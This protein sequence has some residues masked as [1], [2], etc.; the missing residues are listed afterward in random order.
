MKNYIRS[1]ILAVGAL[2][3]TMGCNDDFVNTQ[4]LDQVS[5]SAVWT[6]AVLS[7]RF[8]VHIYTYFGQGGFDEQMIASLSDE[9][10][11]THTG[12]GIT[13]ITES[14]SNPADNGWVNYTH[15]WANMYR[16]I[17][18]A[19][20]AIRNL[21]SPQFENRNGV[22]EQLLGEAKF[23]RA[24]LYHQ[25]V[26]FY[27]AVPLVD[28]PYELGEADY[29]LPRN[30]ME[31]CINFIVKD[32]DDAASLI[33]NRSMAKGRATG[34]AALALKSRILTYAA[35]DLLD[36]NTAKAKSS[37]MAAYSNPELVSITTGSRAERWQKAK[38]AAK[39]VVDLSSY[40][41]MLNL[42]APATT[43]EGTQNFKN[44][45]YSRNGGEADMILGR[46]FTNA[47]GEA[48][49]SIGLYN[50]PNGYHN[51]A[52]NTPLQQFVDAFELADGTKFNWSNAAHA[53]SPYTGRD[54]R[55]YASVLYDGANWKPRTADVASK[56]PANQI[57]TGQYEIIGESGSK[58][59]YNGLD[60]R[61]SSVEDWNGTRTGYYFRK[62]LDED[63]TIEDQNTRQE[64]PWPVLRYTEAVLNYIEACIELGEEQEARTWLNKIRF[65]AGM[66]AVTDSGDALRNR[67]RNERLIELSFESHRYHDIRRWMIAPVTVGRKADYISVK[68]TL[69]P[70]KSVTLY[71]Y[72]TENY[73]YTYTVLPIDPGT[74][75]RNWLDKMYF[76]PIHRDEINRNQQLKQ[77][78]GF[79]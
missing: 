23:M 78:P 77:N 16:G 43:A 38:A 72:D 41:Y 50:G 3:T 29:E 67:L 64:I 22:V 18:A 14:R 63:P 35:S 27:G 48:G 9:A 49:G 66:P 47:K 28:R 2:F 46:Y 39:A 44:V 33:G 59:T 30:T 4:P 8:V 42:S 40:Q 65:R 36:A 53:K 24:F 31:E 60:T 57:Q 68:G 13:T 69:K 7:E 12:R 17:R 56:D 71:K 26:R 34:V 51:W 21:S 55:F 20:I 6:D 62:F 73:D 25:L 11:F 1:I 79:E 74:E 75:N 54:P 5:E 32:C 10:M 37:A 45:A 76:L 52:G 15:A 58:V 19:N 70:G 61:L